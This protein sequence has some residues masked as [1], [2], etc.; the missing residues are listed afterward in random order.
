MKRLVAFLLLALF[1][2]GVRPA[3]HEVRPCYLELRQ[4]SADTFDVLWKVPAAGGDRRLGIYVR[5]PDGSEESRADA[6]HMGGRFA[7]DAFLER[8]TVRHPGGLAGQTIHIDG[9]ALDDGPMCSCGSS[10]S[11]EPRS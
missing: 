11:T 6:G 1:N 5:F 9:F 4:T 7:G 10:A 2:V 3:A 8:W